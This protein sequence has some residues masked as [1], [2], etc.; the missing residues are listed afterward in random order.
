[1]RREPLKRGGDAVGPYVV[2][3]LLGVGQEGDVFLVRHGQTGAFR[4]LKLLRG[5]EMVLEAEHTVRH[6]QRLRRVASVKQLRGW[7]VEKS[8]SGVSE[9][10]WLAFDYIRGE[11]L[12]TRIAGGGIKDPLRTLLALANALGPIHRR[13]IGICDMD[14]ARNVLIE[15]G[16]GLIKFCDLDAGTTREAPPPLAMDFVELRHTARLL[17]RNRG[18]GVPQPVRA[19]LD[20]PQSI[21]D[22]I[23]RLRA[24]CR[25]QVAH[26]SGRT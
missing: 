3:R 15:R 8:R 20:A 5:R 24:L 26:S 18:L 6:Y 16:T 2:L 19:A 22:V 21:F 10:P 4:S 9:R 13:G 7:G 11:T 23:P 17:Y 25:L 12:A 14:R 1:M